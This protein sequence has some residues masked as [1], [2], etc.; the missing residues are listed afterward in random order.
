MT[1]L[2]GDDDERQSLLI[3]F[4][5]MTSR[6]ITGMSFA[7]I[8]KQRLGS[9]LRGTFLGLGSPLAARMAAQLEFDWL[10]VDMEHGAAS[11][12]NLPD[13]LVAVE[14]T[15]CSPVVRVVSNN[16]DRIKR[17]L[18]LGAVGVMVPYISSA[19]A[20]E[21]AV[22]YTRYPPAGC[23]GVASSTV[24][25]GMSLRTDQYHR[26]ANEKVLTVL[27]IETREGVDQANEIAAVD[28]VDVLFIGPLDL[29]FNLGCPKDYDHPDLLAALDT[30]ISACRANGKAAG[31]LS[32]VDRAPHHL[33]RGFT[34]VAV[35]S[36]VGALRMGL[37]RQRDA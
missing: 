9:P 23:R 22:S 28:G 15:G 34:F 16:Q 35:G 24:A 5:A 12:S 6:R 3:A 4:F 8:D 30:V 18:D 11:E 25:T 20:A 31:I 36:D 33:D 17:A 13:L 32:S 2:N 7:W 37:E 26:E 21:R 27:Q 19:A 14:G 29:S 1:G 10:L